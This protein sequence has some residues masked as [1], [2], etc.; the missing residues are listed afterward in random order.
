MGIGV[1][2]GGAALSEM[3]REDVGRV[4]IFLCGHCKRL[5]AISISGPFSDD[6]NAHM[7]DDPYATPIASLKNDVSGSPAFFVVAKRKF[8][9]MFILGAGFYFTYWVYKNWKLQRAAGHFVLPLIRTF[10]SVF[11]IYS[12]FT[13]IN[14]RII[15]S[16]RQFDWH[17]RSMALGLILV[18][19]ASVVA[20]WLL[21]LSLGLVLTIL[22]L[23]LQTYCYSCAQEAINFAENDPEGLSNSTLTWA[24]GFWMVMGVCVWALMG[25]FYF[26][27]LRLSLLSSVS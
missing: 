1:S 20:P 5:R 22:I 6:D 25:Y 15:A 23:A 21:S 9:L 11:F 26:F 7:T 19:M 14:Q 17:P 16:Q 18:A 12:L 4:L 3:R 27:V 8:V 10:F 2:A 13:R 24:N